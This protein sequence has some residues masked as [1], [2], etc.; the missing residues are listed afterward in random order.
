M[1]LSE[2]IIQEKIRRDLTWLIASPLLMS[3]ATTERVQSEVRTAVERFLNLS[4]PI[5][6]AS[7]PRFRA[8][9]PLGRWFE[10]VLEI[11]LQLTYGCDNVHRSVNDESGGELDFV[12]T[13]AH[14][15]LHIEC[16]VKYFLYRNELGDGLKAFVGPLLR[17]RLD[18]KYRKMLD[19]QLRRTVPPELCGGRPVLRVMWLSGRIFYPTLANSG[20][21]KAETCLA[22]LNPSHLR[23]Q[24][25]SLSEIFPNRYKDDIIVELPSLWWLTNL[26]DLDQECLGVFLDFKGMGD[27]PKMLAQ[28]KISSGKIT[29]LARGFVLS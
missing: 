15:V 10:S 24:F 7:P 16:A 19:V 23:G 22:E 6:V 17:D 4:P 11:G 28:V 3:N 20:A 5:P 29:E 13:L 18:L 12:V 27:R 9:F 26:D 25:G 8:D 2:S 1:F 21:S 14:E